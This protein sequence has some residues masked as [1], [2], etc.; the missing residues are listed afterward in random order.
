ML[1]QKMID[2]YKALHLKKYNIVLS[3]EQATE[4]AIMLFN[5]MAILICT[6][7]ARKRLG[8]P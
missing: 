8:L 1:S 5:L 3:D 7:E 6:P 2:K 4:Q